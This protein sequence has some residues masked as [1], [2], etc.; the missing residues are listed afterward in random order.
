MHGSGSVQEYVSKMAIAFVALLPAVA[1]AHDTGDR[2]HEL[3][4]CAHQAY[5]QQ[6]VQHC[7]PPSS[8]V[9]PSFSTLAARHGV[10]MSGGLSLSFG[11][12]GNVA[13]Y[14]FRD[15]TQTVLEQGNCASLPPPAPVVPPVTPPVVPPVTPPVVPPVTPPVVPPVTPPGNNVGQPEIDLPPQVIS[16]PLRPRRSTWSVVDIENGASQ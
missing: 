3:P 4:H 15:R 2:D 13:S 12:S 10:T 16:T 5:E 1:S 6:C 8:G 11:C 7:V 14:E 9:C